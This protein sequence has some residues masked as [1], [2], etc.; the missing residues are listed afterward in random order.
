VPGTKSAAEMLEEAEGLVAEKVAARAAHR[1]RRTVAD[2]RAENREL[3]ATI[4]ALEEDIATLEA[5][6]AKPKPVKP[7]PLA[8]RS[9][10]GKLPAAFVALASDWHTCEIVTARQTG[11]RNVHNQ[12]IGT[13][14]A[15][16]WARG[17][18]RMCKDEQ[19]RAD[20]RTL[21]LWLGGDFLV[22]DGLHYK[23]ERACDVAPPEEARLIRDILVQVIA[24]VRAEV[25][26]PRIVIPTSWG[27]HDRTTDKIVP[28]HA[29][30]YSHMQAVY[31]DLARWFAN[32][33]TIEFRIAE[34]EW[35]SVDVHGYPLLFH[36]GH[37]IRYGGGVGGL[38][39]PLLRQLGRLRS[40][41]DFR[42][43]CVGHFH[44]RGMYQ[45]GAAFSNGSL[46]GPNGYSM[47]MGLPSEAPAQVAFLI[48]LERREVSNYF[49]IW[50]E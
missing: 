45:G 9:R 17:L 23:S 14:R 1:H 49:A 19:A 10:G 2:L 30:D 5:L 25:D 13:E 31:R 8:K 34:S 38:A 27:N 40:D 37:A 12:D 41:Y 11:G 24:H 33:K 6:R 18:V 3:N 4:D 36:H 22:N 26:V 44:Q 7:M 42:T 43:L 29:G 16:R 50:G 39:V 35:Q 32:D 20:V 15:W 47:D 21:V 46:V 48:D 28:G